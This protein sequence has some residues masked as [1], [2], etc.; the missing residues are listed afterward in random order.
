MCVCGGGRV[1]RGGVVDWEV[2]FKTIQYNSVLL[3]F[4]LPFYDALVV[5]DHAIGQRKWEKCFGWHL[6]RVNK[7]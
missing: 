4:L 3:Q 5:S 2:L 6:L 1:R 7:K